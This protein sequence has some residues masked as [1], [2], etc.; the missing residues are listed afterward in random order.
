MILQEGI[1]GCVWGGSEQGLLGL[2]RST[3]NANP[4]PRRLLRLKGRT[5][6]RIRLRWLYLFSITCRKAELDLSVEL[7]PDIGNCNCPR[8]AATPVPHGPLIGRTQITPKKSPYSRLAIRA[9]EPK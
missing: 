5:I 3:Y 6:A 2:S 1:L 8:V 4:I 7:H 9:I